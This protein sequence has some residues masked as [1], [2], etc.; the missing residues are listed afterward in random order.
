MKDSIVGFTKGM[1][2]R[3]EVLDDPNLPKKAKDLI[4]KYIK[5]DIKRHEDIIT[6]LEKQLQHEEEIENG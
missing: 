6:F 3:M 1:R 2:E 4:L 5:K